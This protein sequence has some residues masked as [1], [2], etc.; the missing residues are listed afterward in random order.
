MKTLS[1]IPDRWDDEQPVSAAD[2]VDDVALLLH[3]S[4]ALGAD[5]AVTNYGG[6][7]TSCKVAELD[8][9]SGDPV[10]VLW[11]K[12]SGGD[13]G[14]LTRAGLASLSLPDLRRLQRRY[15]GVEH[16]SEMADLLRH[17]VF[18]L[19]PAAPSIDTPLHAFVP[20]KHIDH[21]HPDAIIA[22]AAA[23]DGEALV[24]QI[25]GREVLWLP[26]RRPGW[27]L[28]QMLGRL[29][30]AHPRARGAVLGGH[31]LVS[32]ADTS[33]ACYQ[34]SLELIDRAASFLHDHG[35][36]TGERA[37]GAVVARPLPEAERRQRAAEL[38]P[39]LRGLAAGDRVVGR[40]DDSPACLD[41][42]SRVEAP[43]L[44]DM[45]TSCPDHFL[46]TRLRPLFADLPPRTPLEDAAACLRPLFEEYR[47]RYSRYYETYREPDSPPMRGA[48]PA[49]VLLPGIGM[50][51]FGQ[52]AATARLAG[53]YYLNAIAVMRGAQSVSAYQALTEHERFQVEYWDLEEAKLRRLPAPR[54]LA[55]KV[56]LVLGGA[57]GIGRAVAHHLA[58]QGAAVVIGDL[59]V[60]AAER[61]ATELG[62]PDIAV[63]AAVDVRDERSVRRMVEAAALAFGGLDIAVLSAGL[64]RSRPLLETSVDDWDAQHEVMAR[65][66]FIA[67]R[68]TA[69][70]MRRQ[71]RG[72]DIVIIAS[73]NAVVAGQHNAAYASAK[74]A[75]AH[76][77]RLL[78]AELGEHRIRV[79]GVNPDGV[80]RGSGI[81]ADGW[82]DQR[83]A[84]Y[85]VRP[86]ELGAFY[87]SRTL[88]KEEVL[89]EDVAAAV[90]VLVGPDLRKTTGMILPVDGG[91]PAAFL[92]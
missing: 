44:A 7:N 76:L 68:E 56:A 21:L 81:F 60:D 4:R 62:G 8:P 9:I 51:S 1:V 55:G 33:R 61:V 70:L 58:T 11:V 63:A 37:F 23:R 59:A 90:A 79:N 87:A 16:E 88:L 72:G 10:E 67:A 36:G 52:D 73:K 74:A 71:G 85:G 5:R 54:R 26:Y 75:Q 38:A 82:G 15:R 42:L 2:A 57:S 83:A 43:A 25:F 84:A 78:A 92:R 29:V 13:L 30:A 45:G 46:R 20:Y 50:W 80:V 69:A 39:V 64:A 19:N 41:F 3:R 14:T 27:E 17:A 40:F 18:A 47:Q 91:I 65:G 35:A 48:D 22:L 49:I 12:A 28:G 86:D 34:T 32:W 31:G 53:E 6:G 77:V 24:A 89:P 66:S